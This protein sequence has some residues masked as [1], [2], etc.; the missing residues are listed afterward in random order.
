M[1]GLKKHDK[2]NSWALVLYDGSMQNNRLGL[3]SSKIIT[4]NAPKAAPKMEKKAPEKYHRYIAS[5]TF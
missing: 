1:R 5:D 2:K 3:N 4:D